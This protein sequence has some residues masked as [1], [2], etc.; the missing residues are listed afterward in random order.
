MGL[1]P[2]KC[3]KWDNRAYTRISNNPA[4][5]F[6]TGIP[7]SKISRFEMGNLSGEFDT[8][9]CL[10]T[11]DRIQLRHNCL[12]ASRIVANNI[13]QKNLGLSNYRFK[14]R[15]FPHHVLRENITATGAGADRVSDG[16]RRAFGKPIGT[17][18]RLTKGQKVFSIYVNSDA[19][20]M[21]HA[22]KAMKIAMA[23]LPDVI[24]LVVKPVAKTEAKPAENKN[25][26][27]LP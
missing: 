27:T 4:D 12:E 9:L 13:L 24:K 25:Q 20:S 22:K 15:V 21:K 7:G 17:A 3:Y 19:E 16:M 5:S 10:V 26:H 2:S 6:I 8:E 14:I 11:T 1:R 23:K 18:A